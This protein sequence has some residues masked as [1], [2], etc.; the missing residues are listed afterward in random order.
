MCLRLLVVSRNKD[1][2]ILIDLFLFESYFNRWLLIVMQFQI[3]YF[4][5][6]ILIYV[7]L[8]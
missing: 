7:D 5:S 4:R 3:Q 6:I 2:L 1:E 8:I